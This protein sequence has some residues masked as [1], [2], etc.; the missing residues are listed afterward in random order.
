VSVA[1]ASSGAPDNAFINSKEDE[2]G[3][4]TLGTAGA[5]DKADI[6]GAWSTATVAADHVAYLDLA[7][8]RLSAS[9]NTFVGFE[10]NQSR[11]T[12]TNAA[13]SVVPCRKSGDVLIS[14]EIGSGTV[15]K[16]FRWDTTTSDPVVTACASTGT[17]TELTLAAGGAEASLNS[18]RI[19]SFLP[20]GGGSQLEAGTFGEAAVNLQ[21]L[22]DKV[23]G[24]TDA[25]CKFFRRM[26]VNT[27]S[28]SALDSSLQDWVP[29]L[30]VVARACETPPGGGGG[31]DTPPA[32]PSITAPTGCLNTRTAT[33]TGTAAPGTTVTLLDGSVAVAFADADPTTG[34]WSA[35]L[36]NLSDGD[37]VLT[38]EAT[39]ATTG[40]TSDRSAPVTLCVKRTPTGGDG[41]STPTGGDGTATGGDGSTPAT[42]DVAGVQDP[43]VVASNA[44][45][46][47]APKAM[48]LGFDG[49]CALKP[50]NAYVTLKGVRRV[51]FMVD[52][53][54]LR[55][56]RKPD[57]HGQFVTRIDPAKL[58]AG[59]HRLTAK[60]TF[61]ARGKKA[62]VVSVRFRKCDKCVS[63]RS[64][65]IRVPS[66]KADPVVSATVL[67]NGRRSQVL[68]GRRLT[69]RV[70]LT[71][72]PKGRFTV[73]I[74]A[75][76]RSGRTATTTREY[77]TCTPKPA[78]KK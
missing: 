33:V 14:Y 39:D 16:V 43:G 38:A 6:V 74:R 44:V 77:R 41:G 68:R 51:R 60:V 65:R 75:R 78:R 54:L 63:R 64:F 47:A 55:T 15:I 31:G 25:P 36:A 50:F 5:P 57:K 12:F 49:K 18:A 8:H 9:G 21:S 2:P 29:G 61:R 46:P 48:R 3:N 20:P 40:L 23:N 69:S 71:G 42:G 13:G 66:R 67:V 58:G 76:L 56:V 10:L 4:W 17:F 30:D 19:A 1:D 73:K 70:R 32:A 34:A 28:S 7:F 52:G 22:A 27:R 26:S 62:R 24:P 37:H 59:Q 35:S 53:K 72:L 11:D 45:N